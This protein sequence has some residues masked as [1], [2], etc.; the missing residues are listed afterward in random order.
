MLKKSSLNKENMSRVKKSGVHH[1]EK[2][3][4]GKSSRSSRNHDKDLKLISHQHNLQLKTLKQSYDVRIQK[5]LD[6]QAHQ[7]A[8]LKQEMTELNRGHIE[9]TIRDQN[10]QIQSEVIGLQRD[11]EAQLQQLN[12][13]Y[14]RKMEELTQTKAQLMNEQ[15]ARIQL[16]ATH[17][18]ATKDLSNT[19]T[20]LRSLKSQYESNLK[21]LEN[22]LAVSQ[23]QLQGDYQLISTLKEDKDRFMNEIDK[24]TRKLTEHEIDI[25]TCA[26]TKKELTTK[27]Q[28][29]EIDNRDFRQ[30]MQILV[31]K[32]KE[33]SEKVAKAKYDIDELKDSIHQSKFAIEEAQKDMSVEKTKHIAL[34]KEYQTNL[35]RLEA[36]NGALEQCEDKNATSERIIQDMNARYNS[37]RV[38]S[39]K[40]IEE[41][42]K[43]TQENRDYKSEMENERDKMRQVE[44]TLETSRRQLQDQM[45]HLEKSDQHTRQLLDGCQTKND[46]CLQKTTAQSEHIAKLETEIKNSMAIIRNEEVLRKKVK[47][48]DDT[49]QS[50]S[51]DIAKL[52]QQILLKE[53]DA[54]NL[55]QHMEE[56]VK[57][58]DDN[59]SKV[60]K[61]KDQDVLTLRKQLEVMKAQEMEN[62]RKQKD[63]D[64]EKFRKQME[65]T[66]QMKDQ[67]VEKLKRQLHETITE[68]HNM[69]K[70]LDEYMKLKS[71]H[72]K[73]SQWVE[74]M[75][76]QHKELQAS[77]TALGNKL[78][79]TTKRLN[80]SEENMQKSAGI[81]R[82]TE[83]QIAELKSRIEKCLYPGQREVMESQ[84]RD[85]IRERD[86][87]RGKIGDATKEHGEM[88]QKMQHLI[89][90]NEDF[91]VLR[92]RLEME[93]QAMNKIVEQSAQL[94]VELINSQKMI[95][96]KE[97]QLELLSNQLATLIHRV[98]TLEDREKV[99][100]EKLHYSSSPEEVDKLTTSLN[101]CK[102]E[103]KTSRVKFQEMQQI[104]NRIQEQNDLKKN[105]VDSLVK[106]IQESENARDKMTADHTQKEEL[107]A[108]L[109]SCAEE[110]K[111]SNKQL[112]ARIQAVEDQY[113]SSLVNHE[114]LMSESQARISDLQQKLMQSVELERNTRLHGTPPESVPMKKEETAKSVEKKSEKIIAELKNTIAD[115]KRKGP[116]STEL[117]VQAANIPAADQLQQMKMGHAEN[118]RDKEHQIMDVR[119]KTYET[120]LGTIDAAHQNPNTNPNDLYQQVRDIRAKGAAREQQAMSDMLELR[121]INARLANEY[122]AA[123]QVQ[124][125]MLMGANTVQRNQIIQAAR[126]GSTPALM[127]E[128]NRYQTLTGAHRDYM[129][130]QKQ[131]VVQ[132]LQHQQQYISELENQLPLMQSISR[133]MDLQKFPDLTGFSNELG[134]EQQYAVGALG[135]E[136]REAQSQSKS[137]GALESQLNALSA[138]TRSMTETV[139]RYAEKPTVENANMLQQLAQMSPSQIATATQQRA[140]LEDRSAIRTTGLIGVR[141]PEIGPPGKTMSADVAKSEIIFKPDNRP[142]QKYIFD[143]V[144]LQQH[145]E[146]KSIYGPLMARTE[147]Q[148]SNGHDLIAVA[149]GYSPK[150]PKYFRYSIFQ[151][152]VAILFPKIQQ[153][154]GGSDGTVNVQLVKVS[155]MD[156][157]YDMLDEAKVLPSKC[158]YASCEAKK[159]SFKRSDVLEKTMM[160]ALKPS[161]TDVPIE[162]HEI[163]TFSGDNMKGKIHIVDVIFYEK[164]NGDLPEV[165]EMKLVDSSWISYLAD[166]IQDP[167]VKVD[168][169]A[170]AVASMAGDD[171]TQK[172]NERIFMMADRIKM[173]LSQLRTAQ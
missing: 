82:S 35:D 46:V 11:M 74:D 57:A 154:I 26:T 30:K 116:P 67:D 50:K 115:M 156:Q 88:Y 6:S 168:L 148:L 7:D 91:K 3:S 164:A 100:E 96:K 110:R 80:A 111:V 167:D 36:L 146:P 101:N 2:S 119:Q 140:A 147:D 112:E 81:I 17:A 23:E 58:K 1:V 136:K 152:A 63:Q 86:T 43:L 150:N 113:K 33:Q 94:N 61:Q 53:Q 84:L 130:S 83:K 99:L 127:D 10:D 24:L 12:D 169:F 72:E 95:K 105:T 125:E 56:K 66:M 29:A 122:K 165:N 22:A 97:E 87:L 47:A 31:Q 75:K 163:L 92:T 158:T 114:K 129:Q 89:K 153:L 20:E 157:R 133:R 137:I 42:K 68:N 41:M 120:L 8:R 173:F 138:Q 93:S 117:A 40:M 79:E 151:H 143:S 32:E 48:L 27:V 16:Q 121:A 124:S 60:L 141:N 70:G 54:A 64:L 166:V 49:L 77:H 62:L 90:E 4:A 155:A 59:L 44:A 109:K 161:L 139:K 171:K 118:M 135:V 131:D 73:T 132:Q 18:V 78:E 103:L 14:A 39:D 76:R 71:Q 128:M 144:M 108:A 134:R 25:Q 85:L 52:T 126:A 69:K 37:L 149:F 38:R 45:Q 21:S 102:L 98:K 19:Q 65:A 162:S 104:A 34:R 172:A 107:R 28:N 9:Q 145:D 159:Q 106:V 51:Q 170:N 142:A 160:E 13:T 5:L 55:R 15:T 123:R